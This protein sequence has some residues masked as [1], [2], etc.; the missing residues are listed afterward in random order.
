MCLDIH[1]ILIFSNS[2]VPEERTHRKVLVAQLIT[3]STHHASEPGSCDITRGASRTWH[4]DKRP[5]SACRSLSKLTRRHQ[6]NV[7][8]DLHL[9]SSQPGLHAG[10]SRSGAISLCAKGANQAREPTAS[11]QFR[12][13]SGEVSWEHEEEQLRAVPVPDLAS[14]VGYVL[15]EADA[16]R[17]SKE[18]AAWAY[19]P[20]SS[21]V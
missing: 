9:Q 20:A 21:G 16:T 11:R 6:N 13:E 7:D 12:K 19:L 17:H 10:A 8:I 1:I 14:N 18:E 2:T 15:V 3:G 5:L 4:R